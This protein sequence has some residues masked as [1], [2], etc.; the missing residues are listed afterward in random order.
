MCGR[1]RLSVGCFHDGVRDIRSQASVHSICGNDGIN[2]NQQTVEE[3]FGLR[4]LNSHQ[5][6]ALKEA[7]SREEGEIFSLSCSRATDQ[8]RCFF[9]L[10]L[11]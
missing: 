2:M 3:S 8:C 10:L 11:L 7:A 6:P 1:A 9:L 4:R 5:Q